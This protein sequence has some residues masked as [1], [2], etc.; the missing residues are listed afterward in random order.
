MVR[1]RAH[2]QAKMSA[3]KATTDLPADEAMAGFVE[4]RTLLVRLNM[5]LVTQATFPA[6]IALDKGWRVVH[7]SARHIHRPLARVLGLSLC[8]PLARCKWP[9]AH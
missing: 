8:M 6:A 3:S 4:P 7:G 5:T 9:L 1:T 2:R